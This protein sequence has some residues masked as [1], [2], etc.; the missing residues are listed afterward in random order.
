MP[1]SFQ[2]NDLIQERYRVLKPLGEGSMGEVLLVYDLH[3]DRPVAM[4]LLKHKSLSDEE[5]LLRF[6]DEAKC[7]ARLQHPGVISVY[8]IGRAENGQLFFTMRA[9]QGLDFDQLIKRVHQITLR[10]GLWG[11]DKE[12]WSFRRLIQVLK[13]CADAVG[14]AHTQG[15]IHRDLKPQNLIIGP[16]GDPL[17]LDWGIAKLLD[18]VFAPSRVEQFQ[19]FFTPLPQEAHAQDDD[20]VESE[21]IDLK[22]LGFKEG[23]LPTESQLF[24]INDTPV[25]SLTST[26]SPSDPTPITSNKPSP[27]PDWLSSSQHKPLLSSVYEELNTHST[28]SKS[29][30]TLEGT[31]TGTPAYMSP[32]QAQ[33]RSA[34]VDASTDVYALGCVLYHI[35]CGAPPYRGKHVMEVLSKVRAGRFLRLVYDPHAGLPV[36]HLP[37]PNELTQASTELKVSAP[38]ALLRICERAMSY[39][40]QDRYP[41]AIEFA[42]EL[43]AWINGVQQRQEALQL[44]ATLK[45]IRTQQAQLEEEAKRLDLSAQRSLKGLPSWASDM[46]KAPF[47]ELEDQ[48]SALREEVESLDFQVEL[49]LQ[50]TRA[51]AGDLVELHQEA[52]AHY[53]ASHMRLVDAQREREAQRAL[54]YLREHAHSLPQDHH[55]RARYLH[56]LKGEGSVELSLGPFDELTLFSESISRRRLIRS[57]C[58]DSELIS[59]SSL[60][61]QHQKITLLYT[62]LTAGS[63]TL[64]LKRGEITILYPLKLDPRKPST[65]TPPQPHL[66]SDEHTQTAR[67]LVIP[68]VDY[69]KRDERL[70]PLGWYQAGD[71]DVPRALSPVELWL[72][73]FVVKVYPVTHGEYLGFL[74]DLLVRGDEARALR[75]APQEMSS[76]P[77]QLSPPLYAY[78]QNT[79]FSLP[80]NAEELC[81]RKDSPVVMITWWDA[82]A[83]AQWLAEREGRPWR[84]LSEWE[85]EKAAR[86][87]DGRSYPWGDYID[88]SWCCN[89]LSHQGEPGTQPVDSFP[90]DTSPYGVRGTAGNVAEWTLTPH[91]DEP[92]LSERGEAPPADLQAALSSDLPARVAKGGA[93]D[94]GPAFCYSAVRHRGATHYR[95]MSLSFRLGYSVSPKE[96]ASW[97]N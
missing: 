96:E 30:S 32:E 18:D 6:I 27:T 11:V 78:D 95:R 48:A 34:E 10:D 39:E 83:Y 87:V 46:E 73:S 65:L 38:E 17:V 28:G 53:L 3:I 75:H 40:R 50:S 82:C 77:E 89:R 36:A 86:G 59:L 41:N 94:D 4:K 85:W 25:H 43:G 63:Y 57:S 2:P 35:L 51:L 62:S 15:I 72:E 21:T 19:S 20:E 31:I 45:P 16:H 5:R 24:S 58:V 60:L 97:V 91:E 8:D 90:V 71:L 55:A 26:L 93:W 37:S 88:P 1:T 42:Q 68:P 69:L 7:Q 44:L 64:A 29:V 13:Q 49:T 76:S 52:S 70:V 67:S 33:G 80:S 22:Q 81:W 23:E 54:S 56:Y 79:G 14:F 84:L 66:Q 12:G 92:S 74:N 9:V 61:D 47:W